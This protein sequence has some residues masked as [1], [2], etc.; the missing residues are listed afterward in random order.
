VQLGRVD[1]LGLGLGQ[2]RVRLVELEQRQVAA[3]QGVVH[4]PL[5]RLSQLVPLLGDPRH[6]LVDA[7]LL[8]RGVV[9]R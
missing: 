2:L 3:P 6:A 7:L 1:A 4:E 5:A 8:A 9:Q